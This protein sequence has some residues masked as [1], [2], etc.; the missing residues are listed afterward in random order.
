MSG[1]L[2]VATK[3]GSR[4]GRGAELKRGGNDQEHLD[5]THEC[6]LRYCVGCACA[7]GDHFPGC[8]WPEPK[9]S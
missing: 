2:C 1:T 5:H 4:Q 9:G 6:S 3:N 7:T 8:M